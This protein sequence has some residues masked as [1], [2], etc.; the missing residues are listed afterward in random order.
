MRS[1]AQSF[2]KFLALKSFEMLPCQDQ[3]SQGDCDK[4]IPLSQSHYQGSKMRSTKTVRISCSASYQSFCGLW[5][6]IP[7][8]RAS[9]SKTPLLLI[10]WSMS[11]KG[12]PVIGQRSDLGRRAYAYLS[13][14]P[15]QLLAMQTSRLGMDS[16]ESLFPK[17]Y[18]TLTH[19][20]LRAQVGLWSHEADPNAG[21]AQPVH[22]CPPRRHPVRAVTP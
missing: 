6:T 8:L 18:Y 1:E 4:L 2:T 5:P 13:Y 15:A 14:P 12:C 10:W 3:L 17:L 19:D 22:T 16:R 11:C 21:A 9:I 20:I 7:S